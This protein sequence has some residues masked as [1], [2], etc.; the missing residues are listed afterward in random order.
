L[1]DPNSEII[2]FYPTN[3]HVDL[4]GA[5]YE[6][7]GVVLLPFIDRH[8]LVKAM[9]RADKGGQALTEHEKELNKK[10]DV[11]I[12]FEDHTESKSG[13]VQALTQVRSKEGAAVSSLELFA[14]F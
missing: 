7:M 9:A 3:F 4:N 8:R 2:D 13:L 11:L 14:S 1:S 12:F 10:G 6:W 5:P